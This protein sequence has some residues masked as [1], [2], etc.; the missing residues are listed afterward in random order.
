MC[1]EIR[2]YKKLYD[3]VI[4]VP[5]WG[6]EHTWMVTMTVIKDSKV[7]IEAGADAVMG[8]HPHRIQ[9][10][11]YFK[12][13]PVYPS[14]GNFFFPDRFLNTPR[15]TWYPAKGVETKNYPRKYGYPWVDEPTVKVW[16]KYGR[17]GMIAHLEICESKIKK[18][19]SYV[20][21]NE[22]NYLRSLKRLTDILP[23][24]VVLQLTVLGLI[25]GNP[26]LMDLLRHIKNIIKKVKICVC[27]F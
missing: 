26:T 15:P 23:F 27:V 7:L 10:S 11:Y 22:E 21:L 5:H 12:S 19:N 9:S 3:Y 14:L 17:V 24:K 8:G 18:H 6:I 25:Y 13:K 2:Y 4:V 16:P 1:S 20:Y